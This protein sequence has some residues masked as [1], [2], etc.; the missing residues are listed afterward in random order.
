MSTSCP[1]CRIIRGEL[2]AFMLAETAAAI[3]FLS[4]ENHPLVVPTQHIANIY[5]L[6]EPT[7]AV[8]MQLARQAARALKAGLGCE[9]V[10]LTQ[11]NEPAAGQDVFHFHLHV[12]PRWSSVAFAT[13][14]SSAGIVEAQRAKLAQTLRTAWPD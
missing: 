9:G 10:Y 2:P 14:Q 6:D 13:Q 1:F 11:A 5:T 7:G 8:V 12:Y 4:K 3:V